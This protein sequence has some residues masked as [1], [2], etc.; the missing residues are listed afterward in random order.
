MITRN[1]FLL[2]LALVFVASTALSAIAF[3]S[4][5]VVAIADGDTLT[6]LDS[7]H[8]QHR[9]DCEQQQRAG[10]QVAHQTM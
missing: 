2:G 3:V 8:K 7:D 4:G 10:A 1:Q 9:H 5:D 6:I